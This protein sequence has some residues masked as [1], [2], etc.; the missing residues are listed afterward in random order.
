MNFINLFGV[1]V[2]YYCCL[3]RRGVE[4]KVYTYL[5]LGP[6]ERN[7]AVTEKN[8]QAPVSSQNIK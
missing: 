6:P 1:H 2:I 3:L 7:S 5:M 4:L 8:E